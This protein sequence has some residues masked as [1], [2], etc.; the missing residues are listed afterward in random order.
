MIPPRPAMAEPAPQPPADPQVGVYPPPLAE[1][2]RG[3]GS[4]VW[5]RAG[6]ELVD[7]GGGIAVS[8]LGHCHPALNRALAEQAAKVWHLS[9]L[10]ANDARSRLAALLCERTFAD[11]VFLCN[12]GAEAN[13]A[14]LKLARLRGMRACASKRRVISFTGGFHG[15]VGFSLAASAS[16]GMGAAFGPP[17]GFEAAA[18]NDPADAESRFDDDVCAAIVEPVQG[19]GGVNIAGDGFLR[20]LRALCDRHGALLIMDE[21]QSGAGR[22]GALY[23]HTDTGVFPDV[24]TTAKGL[25]GGFPVAA[26]VATE[27]AAATFG[28]GDHGTTYGGN[29]LGCAVAHAVLSEIG[30]E[31]F[32]AGVR[33]RSARLADGLAAINARLG[34]FGDVRV[35]GLLAG[36]DLARGKVADLLPVAARH[37]VLALKTGTNAVRLA[38]PLTIGDDDLDEGLGRLEQAL[39]ALG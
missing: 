14:A 9:N 18:F 34:C 28:V 25:G 33:R 24:M 12:S 36:C 31:G 37:G 30:R 35:A 3:S 39:R 23:R 19:E 21:V 1:I 13:E 32:L 8:S 15:R 11:R 29:P 26:M 10:Y 17:D 5:D 6:N 27:A 2:V 20:A 7:L 4:R 22:T 38:P 16:L